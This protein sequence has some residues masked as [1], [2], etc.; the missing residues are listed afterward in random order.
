[1]WLLYKLYKKYLLIYI[2]VKSKI[3]IN[4]NTCF[5]KIKST[6]SILWYK[7]DNYN[8]IHATIYRD[9]CKIN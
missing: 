2:E 1:M 9:T 4:G 6:T 5:P 7:G 8:N 3:D